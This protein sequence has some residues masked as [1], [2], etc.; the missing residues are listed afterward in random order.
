[1][2]ATTHFPGL[3]I[4]LRGLVDEC[5][6]PDELDWMDMCYRGAR[7]PRKRREKILAMSFANH[8]KIRAV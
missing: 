7:A 3:A 5:F 2:W 6:R 8:E 1:M 4:Y